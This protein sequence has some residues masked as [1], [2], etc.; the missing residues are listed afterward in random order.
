MDKEVLFAQT[1]EKV[2]KLAAEQ[3]NCISEEHVKEE[4][5]PLHLQDGQ[6]QLVFDYLEKNKINSYRK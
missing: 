3:G 5:A 4:F 1:L 6:L 2:K